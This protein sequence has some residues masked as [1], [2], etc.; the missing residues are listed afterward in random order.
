MPSSRESEEGLLELEERIYH[1]KPPKYDDQ[2]PKIL[3]DVVF[4]FWNG[5]KCLERS[6]RHIFGANLT[7]EEAVDSALERNPDNVPS[8]D[9]FVYCRN[10]KL[11]DSDN[12]VGGKLIALDDTLALLRDIFEDRDTITISNMCDHPDRLQRADNRKS[13]QIIGATFLTISSIFSFMILIAI[14]FSH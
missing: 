3:L 13:L 1:S 10:E 9:K 4:R 12:R 11:D 2:E 14:Y 7:V 8:G 6:A 5:W